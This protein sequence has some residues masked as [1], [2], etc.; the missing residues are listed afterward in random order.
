MDKPVIAKTE[1]KAHFPVTVMQQDF[2]SADALNRALSEVILGMEED[3]RDTSQNAARQ[4][5][6]A[7]EGGYQTSGQ[8]NFFDL[9]QPAVSSFCNDL[10]MPA[11]DAYLEHIFEAEARQLS[12]YAFGWANVLR[13]GDWQRPHFHASTG[14]V[15]SGVYYVSV[16]EEQPPKG[17]IDFLNPLPISQHHGYSPCQR[18]Q[19]QAGKLIMFPPYHM[20]YV[21]PVSNQEPRIV[22]AFDILGHRPGPQFVF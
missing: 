19:P 13:D 6:I 11:V 15:A 1:F 3:F 22:I 17:C 12:P 7:T 8:K 9:K 4:D 2:A 14:N 18:V 16:P 10:L 20:H 21:H 5:H